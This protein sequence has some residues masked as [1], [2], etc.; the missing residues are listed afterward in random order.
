MTVPGGEMPF[1]DHLEELRTRFLRALGAVVVGF[2]A[3][4]WLVERFQ[5]V[6]LL[7]APIA[8]YLPSGKLTFTSPTE[9]LMIVL[10]LAF[11]VG[12]LLASPVLL[13][14]VWAFLSPALYERERQGRLPGP[15]RGARAV[16]RRRQPGLR[17]RGAAGAARALQLPGRGAPA[18]D[19]VRR[20]VRLR[21]ADRPRPGPVVRAA[22]RHHHPG[23][24][25][26]RHAGGAA[27]VPALCGRALVRG[28]RRALAGRRRAL[29]ADDDGAAPAA[30]RDRGGR[31]RPDRAP[32]A[33]ARAGG[34]AAVLLFALLLGG[35][36]TP[37]AAQGVP[38]AAGA[39]GG[40]GH[41]PR[42]TGPSA[43]PG[44][45]HGAGPPARPSHRSLTI[46]RPGGFRLPLPARAS[47]LHRHQVS[48]R[49]RRHPRGA[50]ASSCSWATR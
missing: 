37:A 46:L 3:G 28:R 20:L 49:L 8:P 40:T 29:D 34:G 32:P 33:P 17:L 38:D 12:L 13:Y 11:V 44:A 18:D 31:R 1:L 45:R 16:P 6:A 43:G 30:V 25:R 26:P 23:G 2:G 14:Q 4:L 10:K 15:R 24:A 39:G 35:L 41:H 36:A 22:A 42:A 19:H 5:L 7:K 21:A 9:P 47:R 50:E 48:R 27:P